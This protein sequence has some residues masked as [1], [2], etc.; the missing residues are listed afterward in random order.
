MN[1]NVPPAAPVTPPETGASTKLISCFLAFWFNYLATNG[2][3]VLQSMI[4]EFFAA[5]WNN[6]LF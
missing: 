5:L 3:I 2:E 4:K 6:P 1:V